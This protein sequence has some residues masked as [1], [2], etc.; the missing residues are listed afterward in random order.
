MIQILKHFGWTWVG[1]LVSDDDYGLHV[2]RAFQSEL[3][4]S[5]GGC[6]AFLEVLP[7]DSDASEIRRIVQVIKTSTARAIMV[8]AH[9]FHII[10]LMEEVCCCAFDDFFTSV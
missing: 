3:A 8:F 4:Q 5:G 6:L 10:H 9:E 1:L 2:A 7:W